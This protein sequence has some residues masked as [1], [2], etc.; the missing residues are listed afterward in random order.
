MDKGWEFL[1]DDINQDKTLAEE[2][3]GE[4]EV[5]EVLLDENEENLYDMDTF[6][7]NK[8]DKSVSVLPS[9]EKGK[10]EVAGA[11]GKLK[12][13]FTEKFNPFWTKNKK[14]NLKIFISAFC[15]LILLAAALAGIHIYNLLKTVPAPDN[16]IDFKNQDVTFAADVEDNRNFEAMH[17]VADANSLDQLLYNWAN[18]GGEKLENKNVINVMLFGVDSEDG[19]MTGARS[20]TMLLV[21]LNK[22]TKKITLVSFMRDSYT[23]MNINGQDRYFKVNAAYNWGGPATVVKTV[24]DNYKIVIDKYVC[25]DFSTFPKIIDSLGGVTVEVLPYESNYI[26]RTSHFKNFPVGKAVKLSGDEALVFSRIRHSD[27]DGDISRTR[28]QRQVI[29][30]MIDSARGATTGQIDLALNRVFPNIR[31]NYTKTE[32]FSL[33]SQAI[34][35]KWVDFENVQLLSPSVENCKSATVN[36]QFVWVVDYPLE[37]QTLQ[38]ALYSKSNIILDVNRVNPFNMLI[39][40][41]RQTTTKANTTTAIGE[42][43]SQ[44]VV[45][46]TESTTSVFPTGETGTTGVAEETTATA[47]WETLAASKTITTATASEETATLP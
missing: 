12:S 35:Q 9:V 15:F 31:T 3:A 29:M 26:R 17:D 32:I 43:T 13:F 47:W 4:E 27:N 37:A 39:P 36:T 5:V 33:A 7:Y 28:R 14:R 38:L 1:D 46:G 2:V 18:N 42:T 22:K 23:Y 40:K 24:E 6:V 44:S 19:S 25:V 11:K 34:M 16:G 21:S 10:E 8:A 41:P 30:A 20:D 45:T